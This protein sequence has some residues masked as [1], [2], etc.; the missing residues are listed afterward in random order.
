MRRNDDTIRHFASQFVPDEVFGNDRLVNDEYLKL[1]NPPAN[2]PE[3]APAMLAI[4]DGLSTEAAD[5]WARIMA[6]RAATPQGMLAKLDTYESSFA[7]PECASVYDDL[8]VLCGLD[9]S[10]TVEG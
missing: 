10:A 5:L 6:T 3:P 8:R 1:S 2:S 9:P 4:F 7:E